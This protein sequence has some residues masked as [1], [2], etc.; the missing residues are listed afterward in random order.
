MGNGDFGEGE[1]RRQWGRGGEARV[2]RE[3]P[4]GGLGRGRGGGKGH[5][6]R[7]VRG[8][9]G[10]ASRRRRSGEGE[11]P[12]SSRGASRGHGR[13]VQWAKLVRRR[14]GGGP[15]RSRTGDRPWSAGAAVRRRPWAAGNGMESFPAAGGNSLQG[16][17]GWRRHGTRGF[18]AEAASVLG[19]R[20]GCSA[21]RNEGG[22]AKLN[23]ARE[24]I[25]TA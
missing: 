11:R 20:A 12:R 4:R 5:R 19:A 24:W 25:G 7:A 10:G 9:G 8:G 15:Q 17:L 21:L 16:C 23:F 1:G 22:E 18:D 14:A 13:L 6:R 2:A 3:I